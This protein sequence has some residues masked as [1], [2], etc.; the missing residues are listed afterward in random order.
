MTSSKDLIKLAVSVRLPI[1]MLPGVGGDFDSC[2]TS[3]VTNVTVVV[4][5]GDLAVNH[6]PFYCVIWQH[7]ITFCP[8]S[9]LGGI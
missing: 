7:F 5:Q 2:N 1:L 4:S 6:N 9:L 8:D 3:P